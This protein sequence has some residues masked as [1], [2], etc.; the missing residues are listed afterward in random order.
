MSGACAW[1]KGGEPPMTPVGFVE[2][3]TSAGAYILACRTCRESRRLV[4]L[5]E[6]PE[7]TSGEPRCYPPPK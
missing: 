7:G 6:H 1:C 5:D 3:G 4:P 2:Q